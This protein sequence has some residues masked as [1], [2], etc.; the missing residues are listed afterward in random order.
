MTRT[1]IHSDYIPDNAITGVKIAEN[2]ITA[3]EIATNAITTLYVADDSV[4]AD[5]LA[6]S[7]NT[8]IATGVAAL[9]KAGGTMTGALSINSGTANTGLA[10]TSTDTASWL[11]M[12]DP[13]A[14][15]FFGNTGGE[16][17][18]YTADVEALRVDVNGNVGI[19][20]NNPTNS[21]NYNTLDIRGT[22][23][24]QIIAGRGAYQDFFMY[25]NTSAAN[26]GSLNDLAFKAGTTGGMTTPSLYLKDG[27][28]VGIGTASPTTNNLLHIK[29]AGFTRAAIEATGNNQSGLKIIRS[30][31]DYDTNW[32]VYS[33]S[34]STSLRFYG[35]GDRLTLLTNGN[36][37]IGTTS[38][39]QKL[40]V[41]G[42]LK[43]S[44]GYLE[45]DKPNVKG[46]RFLQNDAGNDLS[47]QL[48]DTSNANY[49]TKFNINT[50]GNAT[51]A[52]AIN[53]FKLMD[54]GNASLLITHPDRGTGNISTATHNTGFGYAAFNALTE[55][56]YNVALGVEALSELTTGDYNTAV[57]TYSLGTTQTGNYNTGIG[58]GSLLGVAT[59]DGNTA[60]GMYALRKNTSGSGNVAIGW[61]A[62]IE[63]LTGSLNVAIGKLALTSNTSG[64]Q[65]VAV[66]TNALSTAATRN[67]NVAVGFQ[68]A[69]DIDTSGVVAIG[70][71]AL[72]NSG[73]GYDTVAIGTNAMYS[74][75]SGNS[76]VAVGFNA[77]YANQNGNQNVAVGNGALDTLQSGSSNVGIGRAAGTNVLDGLYNVIVGADSGGSVTSGAKNTIVGWA[78]GSTLQTG[79]DNV[80]IGRGTR[81]SA[82]N[83]DNQIVMGDSVTSA[84]NNTFTIGKDGTDSAIAFGANSVTAPS[85]VRLKEDIQDEE[86][87]LDFINDLRPVTFLW[88][89]EKDI[90]SEMNAYKEGSEERTMN[91]KYNHGFIAQEVKATIDS[92]D[93]KEGFDMWQE[94]ELDGRQRVAP[95]AIMSVM[96]KALQEADA[97]IES[98]TAR[99][100]NAGL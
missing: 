35:G 55:G 48:G 94:D 17:A 44:D 93:L 65:N 43:L 25:T 9:P 80:C 13:T 96:V 49:V 77:L 34:N 98:L 41:A 51:F 89:K 70:F 52:G 78:A 12:T 50:S 53:N 97:K 72:M 23:G 36:V 21:T 88:K 90:P 27:G 45:F 39:S 46:F 74:N 29:K 87:G 7:I 56:D 40:D 84:G 79:T 1:T 81:T 59:G 37:G 68:A 54:L 66:G 2:S 32:E 62:S 15:L 95:S 38:P 85:D 64:T 22:N 73:S 82:T 91:G 83:S 16:F 19:G 28:N 20:T 71:Q 76:N 60:M 8:D 69:Q 5:K 33:P 58:Y 14:T 75:S 11:T 10:I 99:L 24:G 31:S 92:H 86:V 26:I 18:L 6:N 61:D 100:D 3:R 42:N 30:S 47:I 57:G 4:T 63:N 67:G